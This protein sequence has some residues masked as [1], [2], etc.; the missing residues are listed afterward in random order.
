MLTHMDTTTSITTASGGA[1]LHT[2]DWSAPTNTASVVLAHGLGEHCGRY[3]HVATRLVK[4]GYDVRSYDQRGHGRSAGQFGQVNDFNALVVD[5]EKQVKTI[6]DA[7]PSQP[8]FLLAHSMG[9]LV[10]LTALAR[11]DITV[12]GAVLTGAAVTAGKDFHPIVVQAVKALGRILPF[13]PIQKINPKD[14][15]RDPAVVAAYEE[16][17]YVHHKAM[18]ARTGGQLSN[19]IDWLQA[20]LGDVRTPLLVMHGGADRLT[21]PEGSRLVDAKVSSADM[22]LRIFDGLYHEILNE[23][24]SDDILDEI[25]AWLDAHR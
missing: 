10:A 15:S 1:P 20:H 7:H 23:P 9:G 8:V 14:V 21:D 18:N 25:V 5:L 6:Q 11:G 24:E 16:D 12:N 4:A 22:T 17:P 3:E 2:V 13:L 19:A